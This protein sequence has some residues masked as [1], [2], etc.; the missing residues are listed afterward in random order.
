MSLG[1][2]WGDVASAALAAGVSVMSILQ[3]GDW[4][5]GSVL[6][7]YYFSPISLLLIGT[8]I[9]YSMLYWASVSRFF[10]GKCETLTSIAL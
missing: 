7:R 4:A 10:I 9:L 6:A 5:R 1:S 8:R 3:V 2:L